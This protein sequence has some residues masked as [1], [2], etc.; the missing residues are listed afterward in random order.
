[1]SRLTDKAADIWLGEKADNDGLNTEVQRLGALTLQQLGAE[2][3]AKG[4][5]PGSPGADTVADT[6]DVGAAFSRPYQ[7]RDYDQAADEQL[8]EMVGEGIQVLEHA[9]LLRPVFHGQGGDHNVHYSLG[10]GAT[11]LGR[12]ALVQGAVERILS[13]GSL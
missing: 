10:W 7:G 1:M 9:C 12:A 5:G 6:A 2:V 13:G 3:M 11:R 8:M 4:F